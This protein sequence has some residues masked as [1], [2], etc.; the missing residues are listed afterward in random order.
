MTT[1]TRWQNLKI[2]TVAESGIDG[3]TSTAWDA[4]LMPK[5]SQTAAVEWINEGGKD[6]AF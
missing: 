4:L 2:L 6:R 1:V 5:G 3:F